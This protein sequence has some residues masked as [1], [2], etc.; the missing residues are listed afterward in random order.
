MLNMKTLLA[1]SGDK[2]ETPVNGGY[3]GLA[4]N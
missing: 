3:E 2:Q 1:V 4:R